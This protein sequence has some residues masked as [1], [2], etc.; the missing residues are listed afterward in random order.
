MYMYIKTC[1]G[2]LAKNSLQ[3]PRARRY[4]CSYLEPESRRFM[5][6]PLNFPYLNPWRAFDT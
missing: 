4:L 5:I 1:S 6:E 3:A 2:R